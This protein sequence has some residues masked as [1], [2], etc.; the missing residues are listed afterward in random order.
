MQRSAIFEAYQHKL[1]GSMKPEVRKDFDLFFDRYVHD[2]IAGFKKQ[3]KETLKVLT[4][5]EWSRW[6]TNRKIF[7]G[8]RNDKFLY[9]SYEGVGTA[10][11][12]TTV[13]NPGASDKSERAAKD[14]Q[15]RQWDLEKAEYDRMR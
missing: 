2:S 9:W 7:L 14:R 6:S 3:L 4:T 13:E 11:A 1:V 10:I 5:V 8:K 15:R 12:Q